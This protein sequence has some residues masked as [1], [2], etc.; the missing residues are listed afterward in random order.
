MGR[1]RKLSTVTMERVVSKDHWEV[2][3]GLDHKCFPHSV[4]LSSRDWKWYESHL[5][6]LEGA[7]VGFTALKLDSNLSLERDRFF[8]SPGTVY[9]CRIGILPLF[10]GRGLASWFL[11][12]LIRWSEKNS[13]SRITCHTGETNY[14]SRALLKKFR[15]RQIG[16]VVCPAPK[17]T[18]PPLH[19]VVWERPLAA[20]TSLPRAAS[21]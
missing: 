3:R 20:A 21:G 10:R 2:A 17:P 8:T 15:F 14:G 7:A 18:A 16:T 5:V 19:I 13:Y 11:K 12:W 4:W 1:G 6:L 9:F